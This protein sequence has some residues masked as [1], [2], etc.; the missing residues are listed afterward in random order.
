MFDWFSKESDDAIS[1][2]KQDHDKVKDLFDEFEKAESRPAKLSVARKAIAELRIHAALEEEIFYP[3]VRKHVESDIM[4]ESDEEHHV[5]KVL[6]AELDEMNGKGDHYEAKFNVLAENVVHH[7]KEEEDDML[8]EARRLG[9]DYD[10][11][12]QVML[13]RRKELKSEGVPATPEQSMVAKSAKPRPK[14]GKAA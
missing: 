4:N 13:R 12:G 11:L 2:L 6:I 5:I 14:K 1:Q 7:I 10:E 8:P 3:A 9:I